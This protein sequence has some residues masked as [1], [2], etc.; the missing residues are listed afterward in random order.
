[1]EMKGDDSTASFEDVS[2]VANVSFTKSPTAPPSPHVSHEKIVYG[3]IYFSVTLALWMTVGEIY[4][5]C[6]YL[7]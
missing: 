2:S 5:Y 4:N 3:A 6:I 7:C 1:M